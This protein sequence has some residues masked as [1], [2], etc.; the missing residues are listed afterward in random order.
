MSD[1]LFALTD[2]AETR[3]KWVP[4]IRP[5]KVTLAS[6]IAGDRCRDCGVK[7]G[8]V[9]GQGSIA[10][11][12]TFALCET[13]LPLDGHDLTREQDEAREE[14]RSA[15]RPP[16]LRVDL[17]GA[18]IWAGVQHDHECETSPHDAG[19][20]VCGICAHWWPVD[21]TRNGAA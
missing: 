4:I 11:V 18:S 8:S 20:H 9:A 19:F 7:V 13:C 6:I 17:C 15:Y 1:T 14:R 12:G 16:T 10:G 5:F 21:P 2:F 3:V